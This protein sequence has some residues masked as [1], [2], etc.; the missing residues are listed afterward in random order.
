MNYFTPA[1]GR[2]QQAKRNGFAAI[3]LIILINDLLAAAAV[4]LFRFG[5]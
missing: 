3:F 5:G 1:I 2:L 4:L